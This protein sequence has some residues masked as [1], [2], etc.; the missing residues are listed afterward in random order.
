[1]NEKFLSN[2]VFLLAINLLVKPFYIFGIDRIIQQRVNESGGEGT[3]GEY[4]AL[5]NLS[6][7]FY[8]L[9]DLGFTDYNKRSIAQKPEVLQQL[10]PNFLA[11][12]ILLSLIY[13]IVLFTLALSLGYQSNVFPLIFF[14]GLIQ[15]FISFIFYFRSNLGG[16]FLFKWDGFFQVLDRILMIAVC[17]VLLWGNLVDN[18]TID[19]FVYAQV[20]SY[21]ATALLCG[22]V[23]LYV[24]KYPPLKFD[25]KMIVEILKKSLPFALL[26]LIMTVYNKI[27]GIMIERMLID[28]AKEADVYARGYRL[29][30]AVQA[31]ALIFASLLMPMFA[32]LLVDKLPVEPLVK[33]GF[34][35]IIFF[36]VSTAFTCFFF[37]EKIMFTLY[38]Q[39]GTTYSAWVFAIL[40]LSFITISIVYVYGTL[41]T[42]NN[43][44]WTLNKIVIIGMI[45]NIV[46]NAILIPYC[47]AF[48]AAL[49]TLIT[50][51]FVSVAHIWM[52][53]IRLE[54]PFNR[55]M[56][57]SIFGFVS[58]T[59]FALYC[60]SISTL[61]WLIAMMLGCVLCVVFAFLTKL[62]DAQS[63]K[64]LLKNR[65]SPEK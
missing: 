33:M 47:K 34:Q 52:A 49:A 56:W 38:G 64:S 15:I 3:Y 60:L 4:F 24:G 44:L 42:A 51:A 29:L 13:F 43:N 27:D 7:L 39:D 22:I 63:L 25:W 10:L 45:A 30:D 61:P 50:Q 46:L 31:F 37:R 32:K 9:L 58:S 35:T 1:M 21:G 17:S 19:H 12:K 18:I 53:Q 62:L 40:M 16:L 14:L 54:I 48:G 11:A 20:F 6:Y 55:S 26:V 5:F 41:L 57:G 2:L 8:I 28:G 59:G 36:S 23:V 65:Q